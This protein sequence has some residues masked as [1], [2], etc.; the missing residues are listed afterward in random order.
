MHRSS[1]TVGALASA[2]AKAQVDLSNPLKSLTGYLEGQSPLRRDVSF[3]YA[4]LADGLDI[5]R[6]SLGKYEIALIQT[7]VINQERSQVYLDTVLLHSSGE[8][9]A[10]EWPVCAV[11][12]IISPKRMGAAL[13]YAR[14]Y[15]LFSMVGIAG[16][17]DLDATDLVASQSE[18]PLRGGV[19]RASKENALTGEQSRS[20][21][22]ALVTEIAEIRDTEKLTV[23][24]RSNL[25]KKMLLSQED[26]SA[27]EAAY[28]TKARELGEQLDVTA[29][30]APLT[31]SFNASYA[32]DRGCLTEPA[33][34]TPR[35]RQTVRHR[36]K[37][38]LRFVSSHPCLICRR[39]PSDPHHIKFAQ[40]AAMGRKVS[41]QFT[42][43]L[44][45]EHHHQLHR[46]GN[47]RTWWADQQIKPI[48]IA[49]ELW[50]KNHDANGP[51]T[52]DTEL[53]QKR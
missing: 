15:T 47:E 36:N 8:W 12:D 30:G 23:W 37:A 33:T 39:Q 26:A 40:P 24:A 44:C 28:A 53:T 25:A 10:S 18:P 19:G 52:N 16:E 14:R 38:H 48:E 27:V 2:L 7:T 11:I 13:T 49:R 4:S 35:L 43:P 22:S 50:A 45:R 34:H 32:D 29:T 41:D 6:K 31:P 21:G 9:V 46:S 3:R 51:A 1:E 20:A 42:V 5:V 17:D